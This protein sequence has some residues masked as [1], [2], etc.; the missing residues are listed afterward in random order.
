MWRSF[1]WILGFWRKKDDKVD[2]QIKTDTAVRQT[3][4]VAIVSHKPSLSLWT[5]Q[6]MMKSYDVD[7]KIRRENSKYSNEEVDYESFMGDEI[8]ID[9]KCF[10]KFEDEFKTEFN[11]AQPQV[12]RMKAS[13]NAKIFLSK[14]DKIPKYLNVEP[15]LLSKNLFETV[16]LASFP[17]SGNS[18]L[19]HYLQSITKILTGSDDIINKDQIKNQNSDGFIGDGRTDNKVWMINSHFPFNKGNNKFSCHKCILLVREPIDCLFSTYNIYIL[20]NL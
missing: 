5:T 12:F 9:E 8:K 16:L 2:I 15:K 3:T 13:P 10:D 7:Y 11:D 14:T 18:L 4:E 17:G 6:H 19:R 20:F 1:D